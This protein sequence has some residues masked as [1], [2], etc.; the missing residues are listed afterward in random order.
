MADFFSLSPE[1]PASNQTGS[2]AAETALSGNGSYGHRK[3]SWT[4]MQLLHHQ[5]DCLGPIGQRLRLRL[6]MSDLGLSPLPL[7]VDRI[8]Y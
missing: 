2:S 6:P 3:C 4:V 7:L 8:Q 1:R 5:K